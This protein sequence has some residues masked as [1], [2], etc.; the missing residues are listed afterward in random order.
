MTNFDDLWLNLTERANARAND[1]IEEL[2]ATH[3]GRVQEYSIEAAGIF[4]DF[5]K[6]LIN[7]DDLNS[8]FQLAD[9]AKV[10]GKIACWVS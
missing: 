1:R 10:K 2:F 4:A 6:N 9:A 7:N 8:L 3:K 5:S